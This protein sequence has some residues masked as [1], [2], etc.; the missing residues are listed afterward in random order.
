MRAEQQAGRNAPATE[1]F[2]VC[3]SADRPR[4]RRTPDR[5]HAEV[6]QCRHH[7]HGH[8][9]NGGLGI[10]GHG[11]RVGA[12][13]LAQGLER[14]ERGARVLVPE[15]VAQLAD[16]SPTERRVGLR[17]GGG[18]RLGDRLG[19]QAAATA[20]SEVEIA[21]H[22]DVAAGR[23]LRILGADAVEDVVIQLVQRHQPVLVTVGFAGA[24]ALDHRG[25]E[26]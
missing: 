11:L 16:G 4:L 18:E 5:H 19:V 15:P 10:V 12:H 8:R 25:R 21:L 1:E 9:G 20:P 17:Q 14:P 7:R 24:Q 6:D 26:D 3:L 23:L 22:L 13:H 2:E